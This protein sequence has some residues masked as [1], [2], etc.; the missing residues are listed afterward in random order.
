MTRCK[1]LILFFVLSV[2]V[3]GQMAWAGTQKK[4]LD[5]VSPHQGGYVPS[6]S[7]FA[8]YLE[9]EGYR[10]TYNNQLHLISSGTEKFRYVFE[11]VKKAQHHIHLEYF[12]F[13]GDSISKELFTRLAQRQAAGVEVR[14]MFDSFGNM[15]N[16]RPL[17]KKD[18]ELLNQ[19]GVEIVPFDPI[20]FPYLNHVLSR[21]HQKN[22]VVDGLVGY[23]GGMNI[24]DYYITGLKDIGPWRDMHVRIE[25]PAVED[26]QRAFFYS[27]EH[28]TKQKLDGETY[29][30]YSHGKDPKA[31]H[32]ESFTTEGTCD[33]LVPNYHYADTVYRGGGTAIVQRIPH[34]APKAMRQAYVAAID[35]AEYN[36]QIINPYFTPTRTVRKA[37]YRAIKRGVKVEIMLPTKSDIPFSP[38]A[39]FYYANKMRKAGAHVYSFNGGFHHSKVMMVD[40]RFCTVGSTNLDSRSLRYDY[41]IN[42]FLFDMKI[43]AQLSDIFAKDKLNSTRYTFDVHRSRGGWKRFVGWFAHLFTPVL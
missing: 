31:E 15:S 20:K 22:I 21:D 6:D 34:K 12:N 30:P 29:F 40:G 11:D 35:A 23:T 8:R 37:L 28:E 1:I 18:V 4:E 7:I 27:W 16:N 43:T 14:A 17:K 42:A 19:H 25:G 33:G 26:M 2:V 32:K 3:Q 24:A 38:D 41:E 13:R 10:I 9:N 39:G 36:I 5:N